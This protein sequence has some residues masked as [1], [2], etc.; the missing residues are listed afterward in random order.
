MTQKYLM[1]GYCWCV[2]ARVST[3]LGLGDCARDIGA[4]KARDTG[5]KT[6]VPVE[7]ELQGIALY[8]FVAGL[9]PI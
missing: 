7:L 3:R 9:D 2:A 8:D 4:W 5:K 6:T 1:D